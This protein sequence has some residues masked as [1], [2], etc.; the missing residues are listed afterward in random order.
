[1]LL[2]NARN[3]GTPPETVNCVEIVEYTSTGDGSTTSAGGGETGP[4]RTVTCVV[5][6]VPAESWIVS[7][8]DVRLATVP[9]SS[10]TVL[11][12]SDWVTGNNAELLEN[13][14]NGATPPE[15]VSVDATCD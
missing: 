2:E 3:G 8:A 7:V 15:M 10:V 14:R 1:M 12:G 6:D 4:G 5:I 11:P 13:A 9:A